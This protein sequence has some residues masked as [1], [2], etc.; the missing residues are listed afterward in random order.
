MNSNSDIQPS[1][2]NQSHLTFKVTVIEPLTSKIFGRERELLKHT[3][4]Y[5]EL[6]RFI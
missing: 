6:V 1:Q 2:S 4:V 3:S 5:V